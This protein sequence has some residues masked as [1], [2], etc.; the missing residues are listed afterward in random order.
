MPRRN[1]P[2]RW[3][4]VLIAVAG[5]FL[6]TAAAAQPSHHPQPPTVTQPP[7]TLPPTT[8]APTTVPTTE[9]PT[10]LPTTTTAPT[11]TT[12][13]PP[14]PSTTEPP[15][16][17][18]TTTTTTEP[19]P[20]PS[21]TEPPIQEPTTTTTT[22]EEPTTTT[23]DVPPDGEGDGGGFGG[24]FLPP[25]DDSTPP[26]AGSGADPSAGVAGSPVADDGDADEVAL[27]SA[28]WLF[29]D[30]RALITPPQPVESDTRPLWLAVLFGLAAGIGLTATASV[31]SN[32]LHRPH[33]EG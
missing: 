12:E 1:R 5:T 26:S 15:I 10:T 11:T 9:P 19:P 2:Q 28:E 7:T 29:S 13:P 31:V 32:N 27:P 20:P 4:L 33:P 30:G 21:T 24:V 8:V 22:P 6:G 18:P 3:A 14:P 17:E 25:A 23:A 16:Q